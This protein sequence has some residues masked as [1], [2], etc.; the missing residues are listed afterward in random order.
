MPIDAI[1]DDV[2]YF[3]KKEEPFAKLLLKPVDQ[4]LETR[5]LQLKN[6]K[7]KMQAMIGMTLTIDFSTIKIGK[8]LWAKRLGHRLI[9]LI[10][11]TT[12]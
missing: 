4:P 12:E 5:E 9:E 2:R 10:P 11:K 8:V 1:V 7:P 6:P 3:S